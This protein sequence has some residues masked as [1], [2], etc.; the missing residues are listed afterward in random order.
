MRFAPTDDQ[1]EFASAVRA[2]LADTATPSAVAAAWGGDVGRHTGLGD[3][4]G[5]I[6][7]AWAALSEMGV[8]ALTVPET[9]GG[10]GMG[11]DDLVGILVECGRAGLPDPLADTVGVSA[12]ALAES[13]DVPGSPAADWLE[14]ITTGA[15]VVSGFGARPLVASASSADGFVLFGSDPARTDP[16]RD[17]PHT[18]GPG[19]A[20]CVLEASEVSLQPL[21]VGRRL[22]C[23]VQGQP[24]P[25]RGRRGVLRG[26]RRSGDRAGIRS[27]GARGCC[28]ARRPLPARCSPSPWST[29]RS[30][31]SSVCRWGASRP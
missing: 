2:L 22:T 31:G 12:P 30:A 18:T 13:L 15:A 7:E 28:D 5:R 27:S 23:V 21:G 19:A 25:R 20:V 10:M 26:G 3:S 4:N 24:R 17:A 11:F 8:L 29:C 14:R 6:P 16:I 1:T 9:H